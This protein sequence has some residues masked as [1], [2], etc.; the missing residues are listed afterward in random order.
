[1]V[2]CI[3]KLRPRPL[4]QCIS[5]A[6]VCTGFA[7]PSTKARATESEAFDQRLLRLDPA[8]RLEQTCDAELM[9]RINRDVRHFKADKVVACTCAEPKLGQHSIKALGAAVRSNGE[10][11]RLK[12]FCRTGPR[13]LDAQDLRYKTGSKIPHEDWQQRYLYD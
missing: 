11:Y 3:F 4:I 13:H 7:F 10:W 12:Y 9:Q 1:M 2:S 5:I 8:T 6:L